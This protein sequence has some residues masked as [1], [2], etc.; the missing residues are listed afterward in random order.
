MTENKSPNEDLFATGA[1][2]TTISDISKDSDTWVEQAAN[3]T[4]AVSGD[5]YVKLDCGVLT[6]NQLNY[7]LNSM[8]FEITYADDNN[9]FLYYNHMLPKE[10][11]LASREP[12]QVGNA[13]AYCHPQKARKGAAAVVNMLRTGKT[14][15]FKMPIPGNGPD[16]YIVHDYTA[17]HDANGNYRGVNEQVYDLMPT[18]K[19]YLQQTGQMLVKDPDARPDTITGASQ[20]QE[21][22]IE[23]DTTTGAS[24]Q[25][26]S[27]PEPQTDATTSASHTD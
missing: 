8:P 18:I 14:E 17:M 20:K 19:W 2:D 1:V 24:Q 6:V 7:L 5:T 4:D 21:T 13:I 12:S 11:M 27:K 15:T 10:K 23:P 3:K 26:E 9:Q 16:K 22:E 25:P